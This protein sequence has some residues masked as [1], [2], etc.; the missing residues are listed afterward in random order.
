MAL[1]TNTAEGGVN[2]DTPTTANTGGASGSAASSAIVGNGNT[3]IFSNAYPA[4]GSLGYQFD[5]GTTSGGSLRWDISEANRLVYRFYVRMSDLPTA[6]E[7]LA[8]IRSSAGYLC[9]ACIG[10]DGK[11]VMQNAS[12]TGISASRATNTFPLDQQV[13]VEIAATKGTST[14]DGIIEYAYYLGDSTNPVYS[15]SST[16]Q[17]TGTASVAQVVLGRNTAANEARTIWYD[18]IHAESLSS[19]WVGPESVAATITNTAEGGVDS[20]V[21]T[22]ANTGGA[23]GDAASLVAVGANNTLIFSSAYPAHGSMGYQFDYGTTD[24]GSLRWNI[25]EQNRLVHSFYVRISSVPTTQEYLGALR[26]SSGNMCIA[27]IGSDGRFI[28]QNAVGTN[29]TASRATNTFPEDQFIRVEIAVTKGSTTGNGTIEYAYYSNNATNPLASWSSSAQNTGTAAISQVVVGRNTGANESRTV[30]YDT[31]RAQTL[32]SGWIGP[33]SPQNVL[34][35]ANLG[36][37]V[38]DIEPYSM[39][40]VDG[41]ASTDSNGGTIVAYSFRQISGP[42]VSLGGTGATRTYKAPG[43]LAGTTVTFGLIVTD[44]QN[45]NSSEDT[46]IHTILQVNER[47]IVGGVQVPIET[48]GVTSQ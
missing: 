36:P 35:V 4:H 23:S 3:L 8:G 13:R 31:I 33:F 14:T 12:G 47:A 10:S 6:Q 26:S 20:V 17:N 32:A 41:T 39:Q 1:V 46:V 37:D 5:Y 29:I 21:P 45:G 15:W 30:W 25:S 28:M 9:I 38:G 34:P 40:V 43:T 2:G 7:Y 48:R 11:F 19:G 27:C 18:S 42:A 22:T 24:G 44:D 16:A